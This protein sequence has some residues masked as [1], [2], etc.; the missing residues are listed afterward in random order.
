MGTG[1]RNVLRLFGAGLVAG[2]SGCGIFGAGN[3]QEYAQLTMENNHEPHMMSVAITTIP[4]AGSGFTEYFSDVWF[5]DAGDEQTFEKGLAFTDHEPELMAL[6]VLDDETASRKQFTFT[7][8]LSELR[9]VITDRGQIE[10]Q[11][12]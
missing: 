9:V 6:V 10:L 8:D 5:V 11:P 1:R 2:L 3:K 12:E 7:S 4:D